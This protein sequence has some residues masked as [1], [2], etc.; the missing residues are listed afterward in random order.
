MR[1]LDGDANRVTVDSGRAP[2]SPAMPEAI[3]WTRM[4]THD[5]AHDTLFGVITDASV[6][7]VVSAAKEPTRGN[8]VKKRRGGAG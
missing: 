4:R 2:R 7:A 8:P 5:L 6:A 3:Y 1:A